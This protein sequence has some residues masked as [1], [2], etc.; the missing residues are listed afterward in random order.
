MHSKESYLLQLMLQGLVSQDCPRVHVWAPS[1]RDCG[2]TRI[3]QLY[4]RQDSFPG[5]YTR[6]EIDSK[7]PVTLS[8][9]APLSCEPVCSKPAPGVMRCSWT[10]SSMWS[11]LGSA[12]THGCRQVCSQHT[13]GLPLPREWTFRKHKD[14]ESNHKKSTC[15]PRPRE[16]VGPCR[17]E[18]SRAKQS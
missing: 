1:C 2:P 16:D 9:Q 8:G 13:Q 11:K 7:E 18:Q 4:C 10:E 5:C 6:L 3:L 14:P 17:A 15:S 12:A